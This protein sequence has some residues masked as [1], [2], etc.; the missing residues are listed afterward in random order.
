LA[1]VIIVQPTKRGVRRLVA[2]FRT[3]WRRVA[4]LRKFT[5]GLRWPRLLACTV[6]RKASLALPHHSITSDYI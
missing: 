3:M 4:A 1:L 6:L 5:I 2:A